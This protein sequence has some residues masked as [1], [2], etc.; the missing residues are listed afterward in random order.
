MFIV[1]LISKLLFM[2]ASAETPVADSTSV[3]RLPDLP[4]DWVC[5]LCGEAKEAFVPIE[6]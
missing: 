4:Y 1:L 3:F 5:P 2:I 6:E